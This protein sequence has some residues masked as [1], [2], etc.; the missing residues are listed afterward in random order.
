MIWRQWLTRNFTHPD[1]VRLVSIIT[2]S[3]LILTFLGSLLMP[4]LLSVAIAYLLDGIVSC[5]KYLRVPHSL[6]LA[7]V[8]CVFLGL[9]VFIILVAIPL[10]WQ[11]TAEL[12]NELPQMFSIAQK[13]LLALLNNYH[14]LSAA[15][16]MGTLTTAFRG[17][18]SSVGQFLFAM[19][20][21]SIPNVL[22][23]GIYLV[24]VP[25]ISLFFLISKQEVL[26][27]L[28]INLFN[29]SRGLLPIWLAINNSI[30]TYIRGKFTEM[31]IVFFVTYLSFVI[32]GLNYSLL[33]SFIVA[34]SVFIPYIG[35]IMVTIPVVAISLVQWGITADFFWLV[36][37]YTIIQLLDGYVLVP[38]LFS[39]RM[40][41][42]PVVI[43]LAIFL[44][45]GIWG[46]WGVF[47]AIPL[48][49]IAKTLLIHWPTVQLDR[50]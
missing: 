32:L 48:A 26:A 36:S 35:A 22:M 9:I 40:K 21:S 27:W 16:L 4:I 38:I 17:E 43:I 47:F 15:E 28:A 2:L 30:A 45:G 49:V 39:E 42:H 24:V 8:F 1:A 41:I 20:V 14:E 44:F 29:E 3:L 37:V 34:V 50:T 46:F 12:G 5:L 11:E 31:S 23:I 25:L 18:L 19:S 33:L 6:A 7:T 10:L 13:R